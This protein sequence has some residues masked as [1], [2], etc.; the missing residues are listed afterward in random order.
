MQIRCATL[1]SV[2]EKV[3]YLNALL[4]AIGLAACGAGPGVGNPKRTELARL[5]QAMKEAL[6]KTLTAAAASP[7]AREGDAEIAVNIVHSYAGVPIDAG[8]R[9]SCLAPSA[10]KAKPGVVERAVRGME[11]VRTEGPPP[12]PAA[13]QWKSWRRKVQEQLVAPEVEAGPSEADLFG[14]GLANDLAR[15]REW[16][17]AW[18]ETPEE[19]G[20]KRWKTGPGERDEGKT[21][22]Q[23]AQ[24]IE[25]V[26]GIE[27][28]QTDY[29][30]QMRAKSVG[31]RR[32]LQLFVDVYDEDR[33]GRAQAAMG[34]TW[35]TLVPQPGDA[36]PPGGLTQ[37]QQ[38][39][40]EAAIYSAWRVV[41]ETEVPLLWKRKFRDCLRE[42]V[43]WGKVRGARGAQMGMGV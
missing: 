20:G 41:A 28:G 2:I 36:S 1:G 39:Q 15:A 19:M 6:R 9:H 3:E 27:E 25:R 10:A 35:T 31:L 4:P 40:W 30:E 37:E 8:S 11:M 21:A 7:E 18:V 16:V 29:N 24:R 12:R 26:L 5:Q 22:E 32:D 42:Q 34:E 43:G 14:S 33:Q 13:P 17:R 23:I 38:E